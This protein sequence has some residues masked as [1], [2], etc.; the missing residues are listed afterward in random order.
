MTL[1]R[2]TAKALREIVRAIDSARTAMVRY[3]WMTMI[4]C[5]ELDRIMKSAKDLVNYEE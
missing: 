5:H 4:Y 3:L 1:K 2:D